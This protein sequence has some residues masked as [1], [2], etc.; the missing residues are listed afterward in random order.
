[1]QEKFDKNQLIG[2]ILIG[3]ILMGW[4]F[5]SNKEQEKTQTAQKTEQK[6][7]TQAVS[8]TVAKAIIPEPVKLDSSVQAKVELLPLSNKHL[9]IKISTQGAQL[10]E[11]SLKDWT[12]Y[13]QENQAHKKPLYL[14]NN[15]NTDFNI[16]FKDKSGKVINTR[17]LIFV[18]SVQGNVVAFTASL[19]SGAFIQFKYELA[20]DYS[21][22]FSIATQGLS[23][24]T[25]APNADLSWQQNALALE[26]GKSQE[27][28]YTEFRYSLN[29]YSQ[30]DYDTNGFTE[31][32]DKLNWISVKQQFFAT[33]LESENGF[34][35]TKGTLTP[36]HDNP[37]YLKDFTFNSIVPIQNNEINQ[38]YTWDFLPLDYDLLK[39]Y[40]TADGKS[41]QF[42]YNVPYGWTKWLDVF[43]LWIYQ[44]L[45]KW[46]IAAGW[47]IF[48]MTIVVKL[49]TSPIMYKQ[50]IQSAK[51]RVLKPEIDE[52]N[53]KNK[54]ADAVKKQQGTM[55]LYRK[56]GV[57][58][59]AGCLPALIQIPI[60]YSLFRFFPNNIA[61]R[62]K[63]FFW[64]DD[65]TAYDS[66]YQ[67]STQI[68][69]L[70]SFYGNHISL[71]TILYCAVLLIYTK[72]STSTMQAPT[73]EGM[74][75]MRFMMYLMPVMFIFWLNS[76]A[77]GLSW[78][79]LVSNAIN[80]LLIIF[81]KNVMIDEKKIHA[82]IQE[83]RA[84]PAKKQSKW[85][86][87]MNDLMQ[88]AQEQQK[89][90]QV[91]KAKRKK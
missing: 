24:I 44:L 70:S 8:Q 75:D 17:D 59:M 20:G 56:A 81:I 57:N 67:W 13:D 41:K 88:Q 84:K 32:K 61:L 76:Y 9:D 42:S 65:L 66:I 55:E 2:F 85:R 68:P 25:S 5:Y 22:K 16:S 91:Q 39:T 47:I 69:L 72:M 15:S 77:S 34:T 80:I 90:T 40:K 3:L 11:A 12:S 26:K 82:K 73:Q 83:N 18:P 36:E 21:L 7:Q 60:F 45:S 79:Y 31:D 71:F 62:G 29:D 49:V 28:I 63:P 33:I 48:L 86:Q 27:L 58:P 52:L 43:Y 78:Y 38:N 10:R 89:Q 50:Y 1:M 30:T 4:L 87:K 23:Q 6:S 35:Q 14:I 19:S 74:P 46:G 54:N 51:M 37:Q 53:E 64:A